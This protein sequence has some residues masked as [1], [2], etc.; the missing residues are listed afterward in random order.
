VSIENLASR[1]EHH[2][3]EIR[4]PGFAVEGDLRGSFFRS[5]VGTGKAVLDLGCRDGT[6]AAYFLEGNA[7]TGLDVDREALARAEARGLTTV[8]GRADERLPF[9]DASFD[10]VVAGEILEHLP[11]PSATLAEVYRVLK[12]GGRLVGTVPNAFRL[13]NRLRFLAGRAPERDPT[14]L[15]LFSPFRMRRE[16]AGF[17]SVDIDFFASRF[18]PLWP[19]GFG[20]TLAFTGLRPG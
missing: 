18:L 14:H 8:W 19:R 7:V 6:L 2:N 1:Y 12:P 11:D 15:Q 10:A 3:Q 13:K 5:N 9:D 20:N 4:G 17:E 16:L